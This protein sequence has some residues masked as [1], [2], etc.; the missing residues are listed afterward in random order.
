MTVIRGNL[1]IGLDEQEI[2]EYGGNSAENPVSNQ[3]ECQ[4][5]A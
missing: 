1:S 5:C 2:H 4:K 3:N